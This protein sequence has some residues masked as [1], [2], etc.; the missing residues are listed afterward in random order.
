MG[1][2]AGGEK[3]VVRY[4]LQDRPTIFTGAL[5]EEGKFIGKGLRGSTRAGQTEKASGT[6]EKGGEHPFG[7]TAVPTGRSAG[8]TATRSEAGGLSITGTT[9]TSDS[10]REKG[11][12]KEVDST[13][14][15]IS[16]EV[17]AGGKTVTVFF[18][19]HCW[20]KQEGEEG[21]A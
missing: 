11:K 15:G 8:S 17:N 10:H 13:W 21:S 7:T 9:T 1:R 18:I 16:R 19:L 12:V 2:A 20:S 5:K 6:A 14:R 3:T 4:A